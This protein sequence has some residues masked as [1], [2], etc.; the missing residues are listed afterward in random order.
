M[1]DLLTSDPQP[2]ATTE[3]ATDAT[4]QPTAGVT[5]TGGATETPTSWIDSLPE[6]YRGE[7]FVSVHKDMGSFMQSMKNQ[8]AMVGKKNGI[9]DFENDSPEVV[10]AFREQLG[11]PVTA[12]GYKIDLP[13]GFNADE[14]F[15]KFTE[16]A[17]KGHLPNDVASELFQLNQ[18]VVQSTVAQMEEAKE[19]QTQEAITAFQSEPRANEMLVN[20]KNVISM[21]DPAG[22]FITNDIVN[23]L[24]ANA[25]NVIKAFDKFSSLISGDKVLKG[26]A[27]EGFSGGSM[28]DRVQGVYNDVKAGRITQES[29]SAKIDA[30]IAQYQN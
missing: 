16:L 10:N 20:A 22:E 18:E 24:G 7:G 29:G 2:T 13:E 4:V 11:A 17:L 8:N 30:I 15:S 5:D 25:V 9:P 28:D 14:S 1:A 19:T 21:I 26:G 3:V 6:E 12:D 23:S 27:Q